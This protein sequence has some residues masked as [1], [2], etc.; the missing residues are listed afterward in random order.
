MTKTEVTTLIPRVGQLDAAL[1][2]AQL[3]SILRE[4]LDTALGLFKASFTPI[5]AKYNPELTAA[6][7][8]LLLSLSLYRSGA[9]YGL[10]LQNLTYRPSTDAP[11]AT[12]GLTRRQ[13]VMHAL[14]TVGLP[15]FWTRAT[16]YMADHHWGSSS[17]HHNDDEIESDG[18]GWWRRYVISARSARAMAWKAALL[19]EP[20]WSAAALA[21]FVRFLATGRYRSLPDRILGL[22]VT[23]Q[24]PASPR[25]V[26]YAFLHRQVLWNSF[27]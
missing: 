25:R 18:N 8:L 13:T 15:W 11:R 10:R 23:P 17:P 2:D 4:P 14:L 7:Q 21:N 27:T 26:S 12:V 19:A 1:L 3:L 5:L 20:V 16:Q 24:T 22:V 9:T 6:F